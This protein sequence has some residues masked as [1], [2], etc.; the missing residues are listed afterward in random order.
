MS[1][2]SSQKTINTLLKTAKAD[3][4]LVTNL[5]N[6]RFITG[7]AV[8]AG[9][10]LL[11][12]K[13]CQLFV[14][15]RYKEIALQSVKKGVIV[16][17]IEQL[18]NE[19]SAKKK[20]GIESED[21]SLARYGKWQTKYKNTKFIQTSGLLEE[22]RREKDP[23]ELQKIKKACAITKKILKEIP[24]LFVVGMSE[25]ELEWVIQCKA[26]EYGALSMA[27][28]TIVAFGENTSKPHH[29][30]TKRTLKKGDLVQID[31]GVEID[32]Y[33]SD[34]SEVYFTGEKTAEQKK[35]LSALKKAFDGAKKM[36]RAGVSNRALD[37]EARRILKAYGYDTEFSHAL[38]HGVGLEIHEGVVISSKAP[39][40]KL[41]K[42]EV[43]TIEPGLYFEGKWGMRIEETIIVSR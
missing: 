15:S 36:V 7:I 43:I 25:Q 32:G 23:E 38:G 42:N 37:K 9:C 31:M 22:M 27:F 35:A 29:H 4:I 19:L 21:V 18:D 11:S 1:F 24:S 28:E 33:A 13:G 10:V 26:R 41:K 40:M 16:Q 3:A 6:I 17:S 34:Y 2:I 5:V 39:L 30:P 20:V 14:D 12:K 8:S